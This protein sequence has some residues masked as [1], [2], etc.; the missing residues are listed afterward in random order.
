MAFAALLATV[1]LTA[2]CTDAAGFTSFARR[3][4]SPTQRLIVIPPQA[5][6]IQEMA[7]QALL[8]AYDS[9]S[10]DVEGVTVPTAYVKFAAKT[11]PAV[12]ASA[13]ASPAPLLLSTLSSFFSASSPKKPQSPPLVLLHGFDSSALEYRRLAPLLAEGGRDVY[14]P[15]ILGWGFN[16]HDDVQ[17]F[18]PAAKMAHLAAFVRTVVG[19]PCVA[20]GASLG[21]ALAITLAVE[22]PSLVSRVVLI[23][24]QGFIDGDGPKD[25][26]DSVAGLGVGVLKSVPLRMFANLIAYKYKAFATWD[27]MRCG[28]LHCFS[29]SWERASVSFLKSGGFVVSDKVPRVTQP[30]LVLWGRNDEIL[31]P[32]TADKFRE[33]LQDCRGLRWIEDC[34]HVPHLEKPAEAAREILA[35]LAADK[36]KTNAKR[37]VL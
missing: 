7:A 17:D 18:T 5:R 32:S 6:E 20:V 2:S 22:S 3:S 21:G 36:D 13:A 29:A 10:V 33:Q 37:K 8:A 31:E 19:Q 1:L 24:A 11:Q 15:D 34:G 23:D 26:P 14:V 12:A 9:A 30:T 35:F 16:A 25:I 28:R 27:A 4:V